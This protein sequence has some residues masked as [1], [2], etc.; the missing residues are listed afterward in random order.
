MEAATSI[1]HG[2]NQER[3]E[4]SELLAAPGGGGQPMKWKAAPERGWPQALGSK[5]FKLKKLD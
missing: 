4:Y 2:S 5:D 1:Y 3:D